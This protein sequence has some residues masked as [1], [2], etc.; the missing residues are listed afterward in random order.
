[1]QRDRYRARGAGFLAD[2][3][4]RADEH[5]LHGI[6]EIVDQRHAR[7]APLRLAG[8]Q[9]R[10]AGVAFPPVLV[11]AF[12]PA[13]DRRQQLRMR[14]IRGV[15]DF[16]RLVAKRAQHVELAFRA[17]R[18]IVAAADAHHLRAALFGFADF[19]RHVRKILRASDIGDIDDRRAVVLHLAGERIQLVVA[20]VSDVCNPA[21]ALPL[22]DGLIS[23]AP[24][25]VVIAS[26]FHA[27]AFDAR[28]ARGR[29]CRGFSRRRSCG[30]RGGEPEQKTLTNRD[31]NH[32]NSPDY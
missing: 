8:N 3:T 6:G 9:I 5:R 31:T 16:M 1:M 13:H 14:G 22:N 15:P 21:F 11:R 10:D 7:T 12:E 20:M 29:F 23:G 30:H 26:E 2:E 28:L 24:L 17:F 27:A 4:E 25:Q 19:A 18:Q 32:G